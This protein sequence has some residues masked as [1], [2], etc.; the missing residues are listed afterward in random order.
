MVSQPVVISV[1]NPSWG[2]YQSPKKEVFETANKLLA[3]IL[4]P[5]YMGNLPTYAKTSSYG[6]FL[7]GYYLQIIQMRQC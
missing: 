2:T 4:M 3:V 6:G 1:R 5:C 7:W